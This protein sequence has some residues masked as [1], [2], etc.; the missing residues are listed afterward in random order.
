MGK[1]NLTRAM[2]S[3]YFTYYHEYVKEIEEHQQAVV[4]MLPAAK[5][6]AYGLE[7]TMPKAQGGL[8]DPTFQQVVNKG[9]FNAH[10]DRRIKAVRAVKELREHIKGIRENDVLDLWL[11]GDTLQQTADK[12]R[13]GKSTV[14]R[15]RD[16]I[17][18][19]I[20]E[21]ENKT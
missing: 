2:L 11:E 18:E 15:C 20:L 8:S 17:I 9:G 12:L 13:I 14:Q 6:A 1:R 19:L 21:G 7:A 3:E 16:K 5:T 10:I 4:S